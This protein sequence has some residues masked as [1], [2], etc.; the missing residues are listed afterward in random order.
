MFERVFVF[1]V[2]S[3]KCMSGF[4]VVVSGLYKVLE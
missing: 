1:S 4:I 2:A 3:S